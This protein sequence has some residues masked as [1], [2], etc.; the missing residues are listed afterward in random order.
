MAL[1]HPRKS[2]LARLSALAS[3]LLGQQRKHIGRAHLETVGG[4]KYVRVPGF[5][6]APS[7]LAPSTCDGVR[8]QWVQVKHATRRWYPQ[9]K[10]GDS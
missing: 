6:G 8:I 4:S 2:R 9:G 10:K 5:L 7:Y 3:Y 1:C